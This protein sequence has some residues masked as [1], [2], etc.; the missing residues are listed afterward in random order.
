MCF[1]QEMSFA[2]AGLGA[3]LSW[4]VW[5][6]SGN[7]KLAAGIFFFFTME[8]LQGIQYFF[9]N[10]VHIGF[11]LLIL[12]ILKGITVLVNNIIFMMIYF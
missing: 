2:F 8:L 6:K 9:I 11:F 12:F 10:Q 7:G 5:T 4:W 1:T 3:F